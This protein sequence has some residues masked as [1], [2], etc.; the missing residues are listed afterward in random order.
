[1]DSPR[2]VIL[3]MGN[4][5]LSDDGSGVE[6]ALVLRDKFSG[7]ENITVK[8]TDRT[9]FNFIEL[10]KDFDIAVLIDSVER[11]NEPGTIHELS[12]DDF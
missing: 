12:L 8:E 3:G 10:L 9:G 6:V 2:I 11:W 4:T 5:I 1:M 7:I